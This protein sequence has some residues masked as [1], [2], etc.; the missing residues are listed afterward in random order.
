LITFINKFP[1]TN[2][3][4]RLDEFNHSPFLLHR[5]WIH[6]EKPPK[7]M[8]QSI[9][10]SRDAIWNR[11]LAR[12]ST[13]GTLGDFGTKTLPKNAACGICKSSVEQYPLK[14]WNEL[15]VRPPIQWFHPKGIQFSLHPYLSWE[16]LMGEST[17]LLQ[18]LAISR[19]KNT[20]PNSRI[21]LPAGP[22]V[23]CTVCHRFLHELCHEEPEGMGD[24][25][26]KVDNINQ[27]RTEKHIGLSD[28]HREI[29]RKSKKKQ[30]HRRCEHSAQFR[31]LMMVH[32][33]K[34]DWNVSDNLRATVPG[35]L[36]PFPSHPCVLKDGLDPECIKNFRRKG[37]K[38]THVVELLQKAED[39][40]NGLE[41]TLTDEIKS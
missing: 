19:Q 1:K 23:R 21:G 14:I 4:Q 8:S 11:G 16:A 32:Y 10:I 24:C 7:G 15:K 9:F 33:R 40:R 2:Q 20:L 5:I 31:E 27:F 18:A 36:N 12:I 34:K 25:L 39:Y 30:F 6:S 3:L 22:I 37:H 35:K 29:K 41:I 17:Y 13:M 26:N 38:P 28:E